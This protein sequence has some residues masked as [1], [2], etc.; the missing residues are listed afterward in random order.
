MQKVIDAL[1]EHAGEVKEDLETEAVILQ[2]RINQALE[3]GEESRVYTLRRGEARKQIKDIKDTY[4]EAKA[5]VDLG[6]QLDMVEPEE[7]R[8]E[9]VRLAKE[10]WYG[11]SIKNPYTGSIGKAMEA[12]MERQ[13]EAKNQEILSHTTPLLDLQN[14]INS[15]E[16]LLYEIG[17][18]IEELDPDT[19]FEP[20]K[21]DSEIITYAAREKP[22]EPIELTEYKFT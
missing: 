10:K 21:D 18:N 9:E 17:E 1:E 13:Q 16:N 5:V 15:Y 14:A 6:E 2:E 7:N 4:R 11:S 3:Y 20:Q 22:D 8:K 12:H 19:P